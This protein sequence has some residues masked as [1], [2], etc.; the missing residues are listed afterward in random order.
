MNYIV[1]FW[2]QNRKKIIIGIGVI[3]FLVI[4]VQILNQI[5]KEQKELAKQN[6]QTEEKEEDLPTQSIIGG[7]SVSEEETKINVDI[8]ETF[9][10]KCNSADITGAY[11]MLT[12]EC[13]E[14]VFPTEESFKSGY[15]DI[16]FATKKIA[17]IEN[18]LST[19]N[20]YTYQVNLYNDIL[21]TGKL[22]ET[23]QTPYQDYITIDQDGK[24]NINSFIYKK[25]IN[26]ESEK[27]GI[28][29]IVESQEIY[30]DNEKYKIKI[31]NNTDKRILIDTRSKSK[32]VYLVGS[33]NV[34]YE[35]FISELS[36]I[37]YEIPANFYRNYTIKFNKIYSSEVETVAIVFSDIVPD[38]EKYMQNK[39]EMLERIQLSVNI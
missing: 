9:I 17:N 34:V 32:S 33:N 24:L 5:A 36:S 7:E 16:I 4:I 20:R 11:N 12:N 1:R 14:V 30:K 2:N 31:E 18:F 10:Q 22:D 6:I 23:D 29:L 26:L 8:I 38:Y 37:L 39:N 15:Y 3:V 25:E 28:K 27:N 35:S 13:K 19:D 21:A